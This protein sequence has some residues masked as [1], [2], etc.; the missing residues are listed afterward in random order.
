[1][2]V[3]LISPEVPITFWSFK[4]ALKFIGKRAS[5]PPLGL[6]TVAAMLPEGW[7]P[8]LVDMNIQKLTDDDLAWAD[9]VMIGG[10]V[11]QRDSA[12]TT[13]ARCKD[14]GLTVVAGGPL[15][16]AE[17]E[18][19]PEVDHFVL[20]EAE[21]SLKPFLDD[22]ATGQ[23]KR[24]YRGEGFPEIT[25][26]PTPL[27]HLANLKR[28]ASMS[29]QYSRG[30]PFNC[31]F[32]NVTTLFG[33]RPRTKTVDQVI[34]ELDS[35]YKAGWKDSVFFVDDN[36]IGKTGRLKN[37]LLPALSRWLSSHPGV[38]FSTEVTINLADDPELMEM[39][40]QAGFD[41]VFVGIETPDDTCLNECGK[42]QNRGRDL[43]EDIRRMQRAGLQVQGGF[44]LGFDGDEPSIFQRQID[45]IQKS[46]I[47]T[48]MVGMLQALPGT[49]LF[50]RVSREGRLCG[51]STGDNVDGTTNFVPTMGLEKLH[52]GYRRVLEHI[53]HPKNYY[54]RLK[55]YLREAPTPRFRKPV[56]M[57]QLMAFARSV[58]RLGII[59]RERLH[60][61]KLIAWT[62]LRRPKLLPVAVT[63]SVC[64]FHFR[65]V[66]HQQFD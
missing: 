20:D 36:F 54:K 45:F 3:L 10:M 13:I 16:T 26:T 34:N 33:H 11:V 9:L 59:G 39:M 4:H 17:H 28:Y 14:A 23:P 53:Y 44:I 15:F 29:L 60:Y 40:V 1:M 37:D 49:K 63:L 48:A 42:V 64:G 30:C 58:Y 55:T 12:R 57:R 52:A 43:I 65:K 25:E 18:S 21:V 27:W 66:A 38:T 22:L 35:L 24:V 61:W 51:D 5:L 2:N 7:S 46:G 6:M 50:N 56:P 31:E 8:R 47:V 19:F 32:C 62:L 41:T